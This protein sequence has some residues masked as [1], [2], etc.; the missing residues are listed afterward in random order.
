MTVVRVEEIFSVQILCFCE[1]LVLVW[2]EV[3]T[4]LNRINYFNEY[5][6]SELWRRL[7]EKIW[8]I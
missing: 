8:L 4:S 7:Y 6:K 3:K 2:V 5:C 1:R